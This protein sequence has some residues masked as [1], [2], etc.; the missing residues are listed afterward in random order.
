MPITIK[1]CP[2]CGHTRGPDESATPECC[3]ACGLFFEKWATRD[4]V[5]RAA[6][7]ASAAEASTASALLLEL[8]KRLFHIPP[9]VNTRWVLG[10]AV[11][12]SLCLMWGI[13]LA[14]LDYRDGEMGGSFM[15]NILVPIHEAGH[16]LF[17]PFG[18]FFTIAGGSLFQL[19]L[20]LIVAGALLWQNR[21]AVGAAVGVW[22]AG[23]S[24][25]DLAPYIYDAKHPRLIMLGGHTG[26][27]GP[28]DWIY[29]LGVFGKVA[30][31]HGYGFIAHKFGILVM[32]GA[33]AGGAALLWRIAKA[34]ETHRI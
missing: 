7:P 18:E 32:L 6:A 1:K 14:G 24:L 34:R 3:P 8:R 25:M 10:R 12:L 2:K 23:V 15:H 9:A 17:I 27:E 30:Q 13:R 26:E 21:D 11:L 5:M 33:I 19:L 4:S 31:A 28:H 29:L 20:P 16:V 22:W